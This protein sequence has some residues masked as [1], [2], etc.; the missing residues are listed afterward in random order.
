MTPPIVWLRSGLKE[1]VNQSPMIE[2]LNFNPL[3]I[4]FSLLNHQWYQ[5][6]EPLHVKLSKVF[7]FLLMLTNRGR[8]DKFFTKINILF[9]R[10]KLQ[11]PNVRAIKVICFDDG[12]TIKDQFG[13]M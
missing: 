5:N 13:V 2:I 6:Y 3:L 11:P 7:P 9:K 1:Y 12:K 8:K 4:T 10:R